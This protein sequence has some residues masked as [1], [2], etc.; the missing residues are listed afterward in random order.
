MNNHK[1]IKSKDYPKA[2]AVCQ[3]SKGNEIHTPPQTDK[4][5][6]EEEWAEAYHGKGTQ[7]Q[8]PLRKWVE[9]KIDQQVE[10]TNLI[11]DLDTDTKIAQALDVY[12]GKLIK[13]IEQKK[14]KYP[15]IIRIS[16]N[17]PR[18]ELQIWG[19]QIALDEV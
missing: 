16:E 15:K 4:T 12:R 2:C 5:T 3:R 1:F 17:T 14:K 18:A 6:W 9:K 7:G 13:K 8:I 11:A 19:F 10:M